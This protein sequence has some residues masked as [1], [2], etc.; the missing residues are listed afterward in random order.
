MCIFR[1]TCAHS[2]SCGY[3]FKKRGI[4]CKEKENILKRKKTERVEDK[5]KSGIETR[6][7]REREREFSQL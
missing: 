6:E 7:V 5:E 1:Y 2:D 3:V 4:E